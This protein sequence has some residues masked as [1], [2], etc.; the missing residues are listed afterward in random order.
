[1]AERPAKIAAD[2]HCRWQGGQSSQNAAVARQGQR[3]Q[4][5]LSRHRRRNGGSVGQ[6]MKINDEM[7]NTVIQATALAVARHGEKTGREFNEI[8][9]SHV[10]KALYPL[11]LDEAAKEVAIYA[12]IENHNHNE[13]GSTAACYAAAIL[14]DA[15]QAIRNLKD[16]E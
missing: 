12:E 7:I 2:K 14:R 5:N 10:I 8:V 11:I 15:E 6:V 13:T 9:S 3:A 1:M 16:A 4:P